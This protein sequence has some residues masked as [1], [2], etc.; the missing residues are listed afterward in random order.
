VYQL[1]TEALL[2]PD[3]VA[4]MEALDIRYRHFGG[5]KRE[6]IGQLCLWGRK[7]RTQP[8]QAVAV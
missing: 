2:D 6:A 4:I 8:A 1:N 5:N 7:C 3:K